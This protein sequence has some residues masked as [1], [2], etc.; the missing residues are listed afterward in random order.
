MM[1]HV[2]G[3][4]AVKARTVGHS[5]PVTLPSAFRFI[6]EGVD[7]MVLPHGLVGLPKDLQARADK[8]G[9]TIEQA[10]TL[11]RGIVLEKDLCWRSFGVS[12]FLLKSSLWSRDRGTDEAN[13]N[14]GLRLRPIC[15]L[16]ILELHQFDGKM[17]KDGW[18]YDPEEGKT[19]KA[20]LR[21]R[22]GKL[23]LRG[24]VGAEVFGE[25]ETWKTASGSEQTC[26]P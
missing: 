20:A 16:L 24:F 15:G 1:L 18:V 11:L 14:A 12:T 2:P 5:G 3:V 10:A 25:T 8:R 23:F 13:P 19:F 4:G 22:D 17:W 6:C 21:K 7:A 9:Q 26:N